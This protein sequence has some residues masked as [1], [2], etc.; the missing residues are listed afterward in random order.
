VEDRCDV[1][2][3]RVVETVDRVDEIDDDCEHCPQ[4]QQCRERRHDI[5]IPVLKI[6]V[7]VAVA[8]LAP[9]TPS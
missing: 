8:A 9:I 1:V 6:A 3:R 7:S 5:D 2:R 4:N